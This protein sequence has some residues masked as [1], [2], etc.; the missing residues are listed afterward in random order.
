MTRAVQEGM[1]LVVGLAFFGAA[2]AAAL[3]AIGIPI[4]AGELVAALVV[5]A[6]V[7]AMLAILLPLRRAR[8]A[9]V[10]AGVAGAAGMAAFFGATL[11]LGRMAGEPLARDALVALLAGAPA[12]AAIISF[13]GAC[14]LARGVRHARTRRVA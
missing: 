14:Y 10:V 13:A 9:L 1:R 7:A 11:A 2:S 12:A 5:D 3:H 8:T 6:S 4:G